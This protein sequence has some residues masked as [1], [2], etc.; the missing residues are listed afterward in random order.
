VYGLGS[1]E[2]GLW[3]GRRATGTKRCGLDWASLREWQATAVIGR[4]ELLSMMKWIT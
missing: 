4:E 2:V 1:K 3:D